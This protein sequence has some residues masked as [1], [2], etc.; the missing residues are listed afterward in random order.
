MGTNKIDPNYC[1]VNTSSTFMLLLTVSVN[2]PNRGDNV[3]C[4]VN[5]HQIPLTLGY[6]LNE[7]ESAQPG[8]VH[9][10]RSTK[11]A[12]TSTKFFKGYN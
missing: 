1:C 12:F 2:K 7:L 3:K 5:I 8:K 11:S 10:L 4:T 6:Y 9:R